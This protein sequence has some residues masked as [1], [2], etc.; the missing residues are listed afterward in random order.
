MNVPWRQGHGTLEE[1]GGR[2]A[3][4]VVGKKDVVGEAGAQGHL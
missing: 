2:C 4:R 3:W 1:Q